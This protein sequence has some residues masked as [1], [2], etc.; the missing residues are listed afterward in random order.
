MAMAKMNPIFAEAQRSVAAHKKCASAL[1]ALRD[2][3][4]FREELLKCANCVLL[5]YKREPAVERLMQ[6]LVSFVQAEGANS[7]EGA[8]EDGLLHFFLDYLVRHHE[9]KDK[10]VR[11]RATQ[12]IGLIMDGLPEDAE[13]SDEL[14]DEMQDKIPLVRLHAAHAL[15]RLQ[16]DLATEMLIRLMSS[17][18]SADVRLDPKWLSI[19]QRV[20]LLRD[21]LRDRDEMLRAH[22]LRKADGKQHADVA[23]LAATE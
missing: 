16:N 14:L 10:A 8:E 22:W 3:P 11:F 12:M 15:H 21:G 7:S 1:A 4:R 9:C 5:V 6:F 23:E 19:K 20:S 13:L 18:T 17:D 2:D